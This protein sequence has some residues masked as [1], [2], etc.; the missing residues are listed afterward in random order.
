MRNVVLKLKWN[1]ESCFMFSFC[2]IHLHK[3]RYSD[4][5][6][7]NSTSATGTKKV[8]SNRGTDDIFIRVALMINY[9]IETG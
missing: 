6:E 4:N 3:C 7:L 9:G 1:R 8:E 5:G 2:G